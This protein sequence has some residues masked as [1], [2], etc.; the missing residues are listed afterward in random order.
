MPIR[1]IDPNKMKIGYIVL[2]D[3]GTKMTKSTQKALGYTPE[4]SE[5]TH[6]GGSIG[7]LRIVEAKWPLSRACNLQTEYVDKGHRITVVKPKYWIDGRRDEVKVG[8]EWSLMANL[9][10]DAIQLFGIKFKWLRKFAFIYGRKRLI[11]SELVA[12]GLYQVGYNFF[13]SRMID[14]IVP[15]DFW[16]NEKFTEV[17]DIW[18][19]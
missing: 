7:G 1:Q 10:Y 12:E 6:V 8:L 9:R 2:V 18:L 17:K 5:Y 19:D 15:A 14:T 4:A 16:D 11:C 3:T 13:G